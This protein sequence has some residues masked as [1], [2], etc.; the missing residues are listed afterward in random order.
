[1]PKT[2]TREREGRVHAAR[3]GHV[4][5][6]TEGFELSV[7]RSDTEVLGSGVQGFQGGRFQYCRGLRA[8]RHRIAPA[9]RAE[10]AQGTP[11][12]SHISPSILVYE[13]NYTRRW[14]IFTATK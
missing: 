3:P 7:W 14:A 5:P 9:A 11:T 13:D 1:M 12:Q 4:S 8:H 2:K 6:A 10:D